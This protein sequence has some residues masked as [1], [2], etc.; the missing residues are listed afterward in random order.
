MRPGT[1]TR[2]VCRIIAHKSQITN[3]MDYGLFKLTD[4]EGKYLIKKF[5]FAP[6][7]PFFR[8]LF[9]GVWT[10]LMIYLFIHSVSCFFPRSIF[11][12]FRNFTYGQRLPTG[13]SISISWKALYPRLQTIRFQNCV[14]KAV[15]KNALNPPLKHR[16][17]SANP[18]S[19]KTR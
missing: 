18:S 1:S 9:G 17:N 13:D 6:L 15:I 2:D 19:C 16:R 5:T 11:S 7:F 8:L 14:A 3:P 12:Q 10:W 4:G